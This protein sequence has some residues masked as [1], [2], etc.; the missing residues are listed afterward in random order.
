MMTRLKTLTIKGLP[1]MIV[2]GI[3]SSTPVAS[4]ALV[5]EEKVLGE[6][7]LNIGLTHSEQLLPLIDELLKQTQIT[8]KELS[9]IAVAGGP[10]SFT[11]LR[12]G[13]ATAKGLAQGLAVPLVSVPTLLALAYLHM[14]RPGLVCP[15]LNARRNEVYTTL[16]RLDR[17]QKYEQ[18]EPYQAVAPGLWGQKLQEYGEL[19]LLCGD[20]ASAYLE[21]WQESLAEKLCLPPAPFL[22]AR[23]ASVAWLGQER[24]ARGEQDD[25]FAL[26]PMYIRSSEAQRKLMAEAESSGR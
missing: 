21:L 11:G 5:S 3:E 7:T 22:T 2:L 25:L 26:K 9:G 19:V 24:L 16:F 12:I 20:G 23:G 8:R 10:G 18:L 15:M 4:V 14:G 13:M 1:E 6:I 17:E